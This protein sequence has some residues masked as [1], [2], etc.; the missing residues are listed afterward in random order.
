MRGEGE[1]EGSVEL[2]SLKNKKELC[3]R[4]DRFWVRVRVSARV[5]A[6]VSAC[7]RVKDRRS[8]LCIS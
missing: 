6:C 8:G 7:V 4:R 1:G 3:D 2:K 5:R